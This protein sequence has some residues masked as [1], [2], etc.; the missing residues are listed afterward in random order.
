[1]MLC[2]ALFFAALS[3]SSSYE[4]M[5]EQNYNIIQSNYEIIII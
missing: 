2:L 3:N 4:L 1:M 5:P